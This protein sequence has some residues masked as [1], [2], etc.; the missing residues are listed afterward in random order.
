MVLSIHSR[1]AWSLRSA[2]ESDLERVCVR[3]PLLLN[4]PGA[5]NI[6]HRFVDRFALDVV[7]IAVR[8]ESSPLRTRERVSDPI[9]EL[10]QLRHVVS[11]AARGRAKLFS[12]KTCSASGT[13][14]L[15]MNA[16]KLSNAALITCRSAPTGYGDRD[17][18]TKRSS[19]VPCT[20]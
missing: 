6:R 20:R 1:S 17:A 16:T 7:R 9:D 19:P 15:R 4:A 11:Y 10:D 14:S 5:R 2:Q 8:I 18:P 12:T 13:S 3:H